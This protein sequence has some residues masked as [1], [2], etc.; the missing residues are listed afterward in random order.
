MDTTPRQDTAHSA[1]LFR[2]LAPLLLL[3]GFWIPA[4]LSLEIE[5][6][7]NEQY[8]F[9]YFVPFFTCYL[10]AMRMRDAP[11]SE[12]SA[13]PFSLIWLPTLALVPLLLIRTANP[14]WRF[15]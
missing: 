10:L 1:P 14:D 8:Q 13:L 5:W 9:G 4:I 7:H 11:A 12:P 2:L 15:G 6:R 3:A